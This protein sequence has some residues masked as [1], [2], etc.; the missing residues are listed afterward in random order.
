MLENVILKGEILEK[1]SYIIKVHDGLIIVYN[2]F[3]TTL[4]NWPRFLYN[5][6]FSYPSLISVAFIAIVSESIHLV[7]GCPSTFPS[8]T[9]FSR[10]PKSLLSVHSFVRFPS[11]IYFIGSIL[12]ALAT[13]WQYWPADAARE[14]SET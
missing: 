4:S 8:S 5:N 3:L 1:N 13:R 2:K 14:Y 6:L 11:I 7:P 10:E 9:A 12:H